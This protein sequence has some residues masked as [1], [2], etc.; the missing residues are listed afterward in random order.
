M[1]ANTLTAVRVNLAAL[2]RI[3]EQTEPQPVLP[4]PL[5][6]TRAV[7]QQCAVSVKAHLLRKARAANLPVTVSASQDTVGKAR[8]RALRVKKESTRAP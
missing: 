7:P 8:A 2:G 5:A 3:Q 4:A 6:R 1:Q